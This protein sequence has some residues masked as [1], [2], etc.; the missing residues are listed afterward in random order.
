MLIW[1]VLLYQHAFKLEV[2]DKM[3]QYYLNV[4]NY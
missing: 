4:Y 2:F 3:N 1:N